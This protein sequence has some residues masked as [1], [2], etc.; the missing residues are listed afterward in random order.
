MPHTVPACPSSVCQCF[1]YNP[2]LA[3]LLFLFLLLLLL[4]LVGL[5]KPGAESSS[6]ESVASFAVPV[7]H[8]KALLKQIHFSWRKLAFVDQQRENQT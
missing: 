4:N 1:C 7:P 2:T 6:C 8:P 5:E 3:R